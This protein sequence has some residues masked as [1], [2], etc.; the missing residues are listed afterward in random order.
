MSYESVDLEYRDGIAYLTLDQAEKGN[1][2]NEAFC[3]EWLEVA[4]ELAER[5]D[6]RAILLSARGKNFSVGG[7]IRMFTE[8]LD[9]LSA[10]IRKWTGR[11][12][13]GIARFARIDAPM[14]ASVHGIAMGGAVGLLASCDLV[15][16][17]K[18]SSFGAAYPQIGFS[19]D[20]G[21]SVSLSARI[22]VARTKRFLLLNEMLDAETAADIGL[23]DFLIDDDELVEKTISAV[24]KIAQ[25]PTK[26]YGEI[27]RLLNRVQEQS[28]EMQLEDEAQGLALVAASDDAREGIMAFVEKRK[29]KFTGK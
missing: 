12:H 10:S 18:S 1:P 14:I 6:L 17:A 24:E 29:A 7:D 3:F 28:L 23:V 22:G 15:Y 11:L 19:C 9:N 5:T 26:A 25:G 13:T 2:F 27:R 8:D 4:N 21:A 20:A 16:A